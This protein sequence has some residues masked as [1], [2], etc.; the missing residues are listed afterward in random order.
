MSKYLWKVPPEMAKESGLTHKGRY[1]GIPV[2]LGNVEFAQAGKEPLEV[3]PV[4]SYMGALFTLVWIIEWLFTP[5]NAKS[6][7]FIEE[8]L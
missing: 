7:F 3:A 8:E 5:P 2:Y 6:L 1:Y 4:Y